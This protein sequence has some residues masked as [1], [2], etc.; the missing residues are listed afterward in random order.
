MEDKAL[1]EFIE[2]IGKLKRTPRTGWVKEKINNPESVAEHSWRTAVLSLVLAK[3]Y[4][5]NNKLVKMAVV[6][7]LEE[8]ITGDIIAMVKEADKET[9]NKRGIEAMEKICSIIGNKEGE[10]LLGLFEEYEKLE[11]EEAKFLKQVETLEMLMQAYEYGK[12]QPEKKAA[13]QPFFTGRTERIITD[14]EIKRIY[15]LLI[16]YL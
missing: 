16:S 2:T 3:P 7:D 15:Q 10:E 5:D 11:S 13:L 6:H 4:L 12:E 8:A 14:P 9:Y 1:I